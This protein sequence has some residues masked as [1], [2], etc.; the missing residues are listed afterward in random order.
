[1]IRSTKNILDLSQDPWKLNDQG[2]RTYNQGWHLVLCE[3]ISRC[4]STVLLGEGYRETTQCLMVG[5]EFRNR[6]WTKADCI[7]LFVRFALK[8]KG[9]QRSKHLALSKWYLALPIYFWKLD[10]TLYNVLPSYYFFPNSEQGEGREAH[11][12]WWIQLP[13]GVH[14]LGPLFP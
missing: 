4:R 2:P 8:V 9:Q 5:E 3:I 6:L 12:P 10:L 13:A 1:M 11:D 14:C 7:Q